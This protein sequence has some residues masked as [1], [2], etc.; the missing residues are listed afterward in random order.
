[1]NALKGIQDAIA[2]RLQRHSVQVLDS[3]KRASKC[4]AFLHVHGCTV[5]QITVRPDYVEIDIN[6][7]TDWLQGSIKVRRVNGYHR[8]WVMVA[9]VMDC[10][11]QWVVREKHR[12]LQWEG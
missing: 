8:E 11:V 6:Q 12:L 2:L 9:K 1:M 5:Q 4:V 7:P 3:V 10:Q